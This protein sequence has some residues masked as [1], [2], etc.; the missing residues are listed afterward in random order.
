MFQTA[1]NQTDC[2]QP[3]VVTQVLKAGAENGIHLSDVHEH[4]H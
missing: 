2:C 1:Q 3:I 4:Q